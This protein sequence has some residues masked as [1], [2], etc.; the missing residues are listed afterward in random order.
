MPR[1][2]VLG[3]AG[4]IDHGKTSLIKALTGIDTDR[5]K[6]EKQRGI[7]IELGFAHLTLNDGQRIGVVDVPGHERF[8]RTM[9]A[10]ASGVDLV[11]LVIAADEGVMP[12]TKEHVDVCQLLGIRDGLVVLTKIDLVEDDWLEL[13]TEDVKIY[14]AQ[15]FLQDAELT[16]VSAQTGQG[17]ER[18]MAVLTEKCASL[19]ERRKGGPFRLPVDRIFTMKGFGTVVTGTSLSGRIEVGQSVVVQP[20]GLKAKV[21]GLQV[22]GREVS[23]ASS[24]LR[25]AVNLQGLERHQFQRG[26][27][28]ASPEALTPSQRLDA[29]LRL[30]KAAPRPLKNR[31][32]VHFHLGAADHLA[33]VIPLGQEVIEPGQEDYV[34]LILEEPAVCLPG[35]HFVIRSYSPPLTIGGGRILSVLPARRKR[36]DLQALAALKTLD[37]GSLTQR[38]A[39]IVQESR[40]TGLSRSDLKAQLGLTDKEIDGPLNELLSQQV[41][42]RYDREGQRMVHAQAL[43]ALGQEI[44]SFIAAFH[45]ANP[46]KPGLPKEEIKTRLKLYADPK[47]VT[48]QVA[49]L[50]E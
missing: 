42:I 39:L 6:E 27:V 37:Q 40:L 13:V 11:A 5:L 50:I 2:I 48:F 38:M 47:V 35:D 43:A 3:T 4:H 23:S 44:E 16:A 25:T 20:R 29:T 15:T 7:T 12:Q 46:L 19:K 24:G 31:A 22:H 8:V 32:S 49:R 18:L 30:I 34:Q 9:V 17:L 1:R 26:D 36:F 45:Q 21:R 28:L 14:L 33:R 41:L 10:G